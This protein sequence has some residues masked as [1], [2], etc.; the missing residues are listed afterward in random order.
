MQQVRDSMPL[1]SDEEALALAGLGLNEHEIEVLLTAD[2]NKVVGYDGEESTG[3]IALF[4]RA[5]A[6]RDAKSVYK[7]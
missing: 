5:S 7:W 2:A 6:G 3:A 4:R 1:S